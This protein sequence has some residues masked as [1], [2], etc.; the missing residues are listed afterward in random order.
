MRAFLILAFLA[1]G[2]CVAPRSLGADENGIID[3]LGG[4]SEEAAAAMA[5]QHCGRYGR[6]ARPDVL[7]ASSAGSSPAIL[8]NCVEALAD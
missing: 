1:L 4:A 7:S 8:F 2:G 5:T 3:A 6:V